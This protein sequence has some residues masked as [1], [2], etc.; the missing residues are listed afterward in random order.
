MRAS[1]KDLVR[2]NPQDVDRLT[3]R[4][5]PLWPFLF[6]ALIGAVAWWVMR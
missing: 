1:S 3:P 4:S 2:V 5:F 6:A